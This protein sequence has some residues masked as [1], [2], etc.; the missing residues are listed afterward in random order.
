MAEDSNVTEL[1]QHVRNLRRDVDYLSKFRYPL[2]VKKRGTSVYDA[3]SF[4]EK[5]VNNVA[6]ELAAIAE[7]F[8]PVEV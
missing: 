2:P 8:S 3:Q 6:E 1:E 4:H 7:G 5:T